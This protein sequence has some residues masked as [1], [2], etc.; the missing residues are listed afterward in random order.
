MNTKNKI[1]ITTAIDYTNDVIHIGHAYQK[2]LADV[3]SRYFKIQGKEVFFLTGTDEHGG[4]I[5]KS[6]KDKGMEVKDYVDS[7]S[8]QDKEQIDALDVAYDRFIRTT[9]ED[10]KKVVKEFWQTIF[11][12][13]LIYLKPFKGL[14]CLSCESFKTDSEA[15]DGFCDIHKKLKLTEHEE[16][17]YFFKWSEFQK[18]LT[19]FFKNNPDFVIPESKYNEMFNFLNDGIEDI[20]ISRENINWGIPVPNDPKQVI[21]VWFDALINY[22]AGGKKAGFWDDDTTIIHFLGK[23]NL[24]WHALLWPAML[25]AAELKLPDVVYAHSFINIEGQKVSKTLGNI[26][27][28]TDLVK[29]FGSDAVRYFLLKRGP[30]NDDVDIS[31]DKI[32]EV[33][34]ADLANGLGNLVQRVSKIGEST[35]YENKATDELSFSEEIVAKLDEFKINE[36][37]ELA[38]AKIADENK[39]I[40]SEKLWGK[41]DEELEKGLERCV[42]N[43][44]QITYDLSPVLPKACAEIEKRFS[45]KIVFGEPLFMRIK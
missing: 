31:I 11:A 4:N 13:D 2:I 10:H 34:N 36:A 14:Y 42:K 41:T 19:D 7:I 25:Q 16:E 18:F 26:I 27:R 3:F 33:Y 23:D 40:E 45:G 30:L 43:I 6:A 9:D 39:F 28:P 32:K 35:N 5:E 1:L 15:V 22:Y 37:I 21:Y 24:R 17:N 29:D 20:S 44:R 12:K 38:Q 8:T